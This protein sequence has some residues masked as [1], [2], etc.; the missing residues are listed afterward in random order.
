M[1]TTP[2]AKLYIHCSYIA[3]KHIHTY[4]LYAHMYT[5]IRTHTRVHTHTHTHTHK[6]SYIHKITYVC[7]YT[8][9]DTIGLLICE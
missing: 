2:C 5:H 3:Y 4:M 9:A 6:H 7:I 1:T 8:P